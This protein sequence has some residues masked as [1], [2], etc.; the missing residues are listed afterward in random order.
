MKTHPA[1]EFTKI[2]RVAEGVTLFTNGSAGIFIP[3]GHEDATEPHDPLKTLVIYTTAAKVMRVIDRQPLEAASS[4]GDCVRCKMARRVTCPVCH[5]VPYTAQCDGCGLQHE[6]CCPECG[7]QWKP[8]CPECKPDDDAAIILVDFGGDEAFR[9]DA[10]RLEHLLKC[11]EPQETV[12]AGIAHVL[13]GRMLVLRTTREIGVLMGVE[14]DAPCDR[15]FEWKE[16]A[17]G[18]T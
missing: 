14:T 16:A 1:F 15:R 9:F 13:T 17:H 5:G 7:G 4:L 2:L 18:G 11:L 6:C 8:V 10:M 12:Q 3:I